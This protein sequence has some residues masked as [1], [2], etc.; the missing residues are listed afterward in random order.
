MRWEPFLPSKGS[1]VLHG[2][3]DYWVIRNSWGTGWG[4]KGYYRIIRGTGACGMNQMVATAMMGT[5]DAEDTKSIV[6]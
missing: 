5:D 3:R 1:T 6:V 4:E 2:E